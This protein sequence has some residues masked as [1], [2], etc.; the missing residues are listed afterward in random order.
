MIEVAASVE[1]ECPASVVFDYLADM[2]NNPQWQRGMETCTWTSEPP[3]RLGS[4][5]DQQARF[6][7]KQ[8]S[9]SFEVTEFE[10]GHRIRIQTVSGTMPIDVTR[11]VTDAPD[12]HA[13][14]TAM[15]RG[16]PKGVFR[17]ASPVMR[18]MVSRSG[19]RDYSRLKEI[20]EAA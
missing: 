19:N 10:T 6:L 4:T 2:S 8:I 7:G 18:L 17:L 11:E 12:G 5:Y 1:I 15:V 20:L 9:S 3:L 16:D 14:V 13:V